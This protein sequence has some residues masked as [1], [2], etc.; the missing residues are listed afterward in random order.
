MGPDPGIM[1]DRTLPDSLK[2]H[3]QQITRSPVL[4]A[5]DLEEMPLSKGA[6]VLIIAIESA[7]DLTIKTLPSSKISAGF[8]IYCGN[9]H[10]PGG[11]KARLKRHFSKDKRPHWHVDHLSL[12]AYH[13]WAFAIE[14]QDECQLVDTL[15]KT[16]GYTL[17]VIGFGASDCKICKSHLLLWTPE[18]DG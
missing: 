6:Y 1:I 12:R 14:G 11:I 7:F 4:Q 15:Q 16:H 8:Y 17:P 13:L 2:K 3:L 9:A 18:E 5:G 10:G